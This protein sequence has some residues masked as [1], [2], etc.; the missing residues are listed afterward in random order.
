[1]RSFYASYAPRAIA[2]GL[3][4]TDSIIVERPALFAPPLLAALGRDAAERSRAT[5]EIAGLDFEP[6][7]AAQDPCDRYEVGGAARAA[8]AAPGASVRVSVYAVCGGARG[9]QPAVVAEMGPG[10]QGSWA[11]V[12][13]HY[14]PPVDDD[15][16][17]LLRRLHPGP[18]NR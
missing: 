14:G 16:L 10:A 8:A 5:G 6:F 17:A 18:E 3:A 12:N 1:V 11:F 7:L 4:A 13:F 2:S 15:L 9:D